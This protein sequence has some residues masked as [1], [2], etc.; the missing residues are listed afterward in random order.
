M[1]QREICIERVSRTYLDLGGLEMLDLELKDRVC[2][3][4]M[5]APLM[6]GAPT[7]QLKLKPSSSI[8]ELSSSSSIETQTQFSQLKL[9]YSN[10][11][12]ATQTQFFLFD[13]Q[14]IEPHPTI[15]PKSRKTY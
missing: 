9:N 8:N 2:W 10:P 4:S 13:L 12:Y 1:Q 11:V 7:L 5:V 14:F 15:T 3:M 6:N